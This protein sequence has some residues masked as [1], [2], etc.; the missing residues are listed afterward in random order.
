MGPDARSVT[1]GSGSIQAVKTRQVTVTDRCPGALLPHQA[2]DGAVVRVRAPGGRVPLHRWRALVALATRY[3]DGNLD[4]TGRGALQLRAVAP[5]DATALAAALADSGWLPSSTHE[6][7]RNMLASPGS[8]RIGCGL[9]DIR[10]L[11]DALDVALCA[12][13]ALAQ[14]SGRFLFGLDDGTDDIRP[15]RADAAVQATSATT[16]RLWLAGY[17]TDL[18]VALH[19]APALLLRAATA[20]R[21]I[22]ADDGGTA[23]RITDLTD[24]VARIV[25]LLGQPAGDFSL[26]TSEVPPSAR[27]SGAPPLNLSHRLLP[28]VRD[29]DTSRCGS[30]A[31][32]GSTERSSCSM[33]DQHSRPGTGPAMLGVVPQVDGRVI[34]AAGTPLGRLTAPQLAQI[35]ALAAE[36][37]VVTPWRSLLL[38][39]L[40]R[41]EPAMATLTAAGLITSAA[42]PLAGVSA[43]A[44]TDCGKALAD[45]RADARRVHNDLRT[46]GP[47]HWSAC[48]RR[49]G[50]PA[51]GVLEITATAAG[52]RYDGPAADAARVAAALA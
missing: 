25:A 35:T 23:W 47:A 36:E 45:V 15:V 26:P 42:A 3:A 39:D 10:P 8:G 9:V 40:A 41:A 28:S 32:E 21:R 1:G 52:Y 11:V 51:T 4:L 29:L 5:S 12:A 34:V 27:S 50:R 30:A 38:P 37:V 20:F 22:Q 24:G 19:E 43:C 13:P 6:R 17:S 46:P 14:L 7:A 44:G 16:A 49:C 18:V 31:G 2:R 33:A 48:E